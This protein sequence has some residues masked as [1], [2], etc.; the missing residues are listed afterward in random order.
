MITRDD[1]LTLDRNDPMK[2]LGDQFDLPDGV[3]YLDG[4]SLGPL[5]RSVPGRVHDVIANE[6]GRGLINSWDEGW[7]ALPHRVG[8]KVASLI[9]ALPG[10]VVITDSTSVN[11]YKVATAAARLARPVDRNV[12]L[13]EPD[14]FPTDRYLARQVC[15]SYGMQLESVEADGLVGRLR[16]GDVAVLMLTHVNYRTGAMHDLVE[17]SRVAHEGGA[18]VIWDL[19][20]S[21]GAVE[22]DLTA[23]DADFAV[24]CGYKFLNG[25]PGAPAF[26][27]AHPRFADVLSQ[28]LVGW[29][30]HDEP[31]GF[32]AEY[33]PAP[34]NRRLLCGTPP[35][36]SIAALECGVD[37]LLNAIPLGAMAA[38]R[39]KSLALSDLFMALADERL[40][41][42]QCVT[43]RDPSKRGSQVCFAGGIDAKQVMIDL[44]ANRVIGDF[45]RG[46][47]QRPDI[48]RFGIT[49]LY[50]RFTDVFDAVEAL[51]S[52]I[53]RQG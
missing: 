34:G 41:E 40:P 15:E 27:W 44:A 31:F 20:H 19:A 25:G 18:V 13:T 16:R 24:G 37:T 11:L 4:N 14:N 35:I 28:P 22:V 48:M 21:A 47:E 43:P 9:G 12:L 39:T 49:P 3:I 50:L 1:C 6:W 45:R 52:V 29:M 10:D 7:M 42:L 23:A 30:G 51:G 53:R 32:E 2:S 33:R 36:L 8:D 26:V 38:V 17:L 46:G 5:P